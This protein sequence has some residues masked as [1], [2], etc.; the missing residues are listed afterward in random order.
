MYFIEFSQGSSISLY[1]SSDFNKRGFRCHSSLGKRS[2]KKNSN[3]GADL[4]FHIKYSIFK[5]IMFCK[6]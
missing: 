2:R 5:D 1:G 4:S 3:E 6:Y